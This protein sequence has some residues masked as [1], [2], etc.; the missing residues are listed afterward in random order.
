MLSLV[1][2]SKK[3]KSLPILK[4][5][6]LNIKENEKIGIMGVNGSGKTT[7]AEIIFGVIKPNKGKIIFSNSNI[8]IKNAVF[9][10]VSFD[11]EL[12]LKSIFKFFC[13]ALK[14]KCGNKKISEKFEK[15]ELENQLNLRYSNLSGG[16]K[17]KFKFLIALLNNP[18]FLLLDEL[19]THLDY[20]W[21]IKI[22]DLVTKYLDTKECVL[23]L[24]SHDSYE[25][26]KLCDRVIVI[27]D[28]VINKDFK[29]S[30]NFEESLLIIKKMVY[31]NDCNN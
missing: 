3:Y 22:V 12:K 17:Q 9:Q 15:F 16:Q 4:D 14:V 1:N 31:D 7:L 19:T 6:N 11:G 27:K 13:S 2:I 21:K 20:E 24:I 23:L 18:N 10:D 26:A 28:N 25:V 29:L 30:S 8:V 5:I